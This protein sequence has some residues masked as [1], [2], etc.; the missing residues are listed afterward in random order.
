MSGESVVE[1]LCSI[2]VDFHKQQNVSA[3][4]L[5]ERS[6]YLETPE[7]LTVENLKPYLARHRDLI[8]RWIQWSEDQRSHPAWVFGRGQAGYFLYCIPANGEDYVFDDG[9]QACAEFIIRVVRQWAQF[10]K[11]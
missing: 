3:V 2:P 8:D 9:C 11:P 10:A 5:M 6:G 4:R 1:R 7:V